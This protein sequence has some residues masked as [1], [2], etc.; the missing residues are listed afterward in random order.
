MFGGLPVA[1]CTAKRGAVEARAQEGGSQQPPGR[2]LRRVGSRS[3]I[4]PRRYIEAPQFVRGPIQ[5]PSRSRPKNVPKS[6]DRAS[7]AMLLPYAHSNAPEW[8]QWTCHGGS[9]AGFGPL[10]Q[11]DAT[12]I[13][14]KDSMA[15]LR[16]AGCWCWGPKKCGQK[17][18][19]WLMVERSCFVLKHAICGQGPFDAQDSTM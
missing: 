3:K 19:S 5:E 10:Q 14:F 2:S 7:A 1:D 15:G 16:T 8:G 9:M 11:T 4:R 6:P 12:Q 17:L 13:F 18:S